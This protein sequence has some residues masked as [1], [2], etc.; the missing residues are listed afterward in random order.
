MSR[1]LGKQAFGLEG[2]TLNDCT[3]H[4]L[5]A[6][7]CPS[8]RRLGGSP[9]GFCWETGFRPI[10]IFGSCNI[11]ETRDMQFLVAPSFF[12]IRRNV[13]RV[14]LLLAVLALMITGAAYAS[15]GVFLFGNDP[16]QMA[17]G[18]S[19][20]AS[21]RTAYWAYMNP[22]SIVDLERRADLACYTVFTDIKMK[23]KGLIGNTFDDT[24]KSQ[25]MFNILSGRRHPSF[26]KRYT[27]F[28]NVYS[29]W[30]GGGLSAF[31][32][33]FATYYIERG[34]PSDIRAYSSGGRLWL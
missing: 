16:V 12:T 20:I 31:A 13:Q 18:S 24:L 2:E 9:C 26:R 14:C 25:G 28:G 6:W 1:L 22:A 30:Y 3:L 7:C 32:Q 27:R 11:M 19:G 10:F 15:E 23:P 34:S 17:R 5:F 33:Y 21:P 8:W 29:Q 4:A